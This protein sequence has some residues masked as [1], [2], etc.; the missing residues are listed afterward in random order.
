MATTGLPPKRIDALLGRYGTTADTM[1]AHIIDAGGEAMLAHV[2][3]YSDRELD[4]IARNEMV[5]HLADIV[6]RR[7]TLAIEGR[8][9]LA[10]LEQISTIA[11]AA[12]G[13]DEARRVE[14]VASLGTKLRG[15][16]RMT[17]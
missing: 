13:W 11:A 15:V 16:N 3:D 9:N 4:W 2:G 7:T 17:L 6:M 10:A 14:E 8:L 1:I 5:G 12:L